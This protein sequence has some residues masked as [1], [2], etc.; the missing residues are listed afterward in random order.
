VQST[1]YTQHSTEIAGS[2]IRFHTGRARVVSVLTPASRP[3]R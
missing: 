2:K 3:N 1:R